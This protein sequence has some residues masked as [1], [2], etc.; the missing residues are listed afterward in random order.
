MK[1]IRT[2]LHDKK[3][4]RNPDEPSHNSTGTKSRWGSQLN[5]LLLLLAVIFNHVRVLPVIPADFH[6]LPIIVQEGG[7]LVA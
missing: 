7:I 3:N 5:L 1:I 6:R 4:H 2:D